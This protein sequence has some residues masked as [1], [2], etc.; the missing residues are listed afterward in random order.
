MTRTYLITLCS[1]ALCVSA[2][3]QPAGRG[4]EGQQHRAPAPDGEDPAIAPLVDRLFLALD[5]N[6]DGVV[7]RVEFESRLAQISRRL[8]RHMAG[9]DEQTPRRQGRRDEALPMVPPGREE[10]RFGRHLE[11]VVADAV[12]RAVREELGRE[13]PPPGDKAAAAMLIFD[14]NGD[15]AIDV[16]ETERTLEH[17][18]SLDMNGDGR[19]DMDELAEARARGQGEGGRLRETFAERDANDDGRLSLEE[20]GG[21]PDRFRWL[22]ANDDGYLTPE[23]LGRRL[24]QLRDRSR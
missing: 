10:G 17:L 21:Q 18:R 12:K 22:D 11:R 20:F 13:G 2:W 14:H 19:V 6:R 7:D 4:R 16:V 3:A 8:L 24:R 9:P 5:A 15:G 1:L 23:E